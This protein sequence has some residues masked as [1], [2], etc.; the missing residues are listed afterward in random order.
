MD[1]CLKFNGFKYVS[2][3]IKQVETYVYQY[4]RKAR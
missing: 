2:I 1:H 3:R 4:C